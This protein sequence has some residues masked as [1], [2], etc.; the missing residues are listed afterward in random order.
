MRSSG[1]CLE[2]GA[3]INSRFFGGG[4][5]AKAKDRIQ[6]PACE[7]EISSDGKTLAKRS[8]K[9]ADLLKLEKSVPELETEL[10][11][12]EKEIEEE[13]KKRVP[14]QLESETKDKAKPWFR[15]G[16]R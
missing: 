16:S 10:A 12:L 15:R 9:L 1:F 14:V 11:R 7:S 6:C 5:M 13:K 2:L 3:L 8:E 4:F